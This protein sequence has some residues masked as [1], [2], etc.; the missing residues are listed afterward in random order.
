MKKVFAVLASSVALVLSTAA[1]V[2]ANSDRV[3]ICQD[4][5]TA[6]CALFFDVGSSG[7]AMCADNYIQ[8][9]LANGPELQGLPLG[10]FK[11]EDDLL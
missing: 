6:F 11:R 3:Q 1:I 4:E 9:C 10:D 8:I 2:H 5:A 7:W